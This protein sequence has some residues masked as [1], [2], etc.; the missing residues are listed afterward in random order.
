MKMG[1]FEKTEFITDKERDKK[2]NKLTEQID[3][4]QKKLAGLQEKTRDQKLKL[5]GLNYD[6]NQLTRKEV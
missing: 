3:K 2:I 1:P 5:A 6:L 4:E